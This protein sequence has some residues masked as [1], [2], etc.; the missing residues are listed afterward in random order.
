MTLCE[1]RRT[2]TATATAA[3]SGSVAVAVAAQDEYRRTGLA[4]KVTGKQLKRD[5]EVVAGR[6]DG[7]GVDA[8]GNSRP[9]GYQSAP[10]DAAI[11]V[12]T[13]PF[14]PQQVSRFLHAWYLAVERHSTG[15]ASPDITRRARDEAEDLLARLRESPALHDLTVNPLLLTLIATV[16][17]HH[18]ALPGSRAELYA[19]ICQVLLWRRQAAK[20][21]AVE[22]RG[23][24]KE[25]IMRL[26]AFEM[27]R[28]QVR[29]LATAEA[30]A[31][32]RPALRRTA[33]DQ[34]VTATEFLDEAASNG[35][36]IE[37]EN[38]VRAFA[39][40]TF[41]EYLAAAHIRE[42]NL[43][44]LLAGKV[45]DT[46]WR[47]T[48]L[49]YAAGADAGPIVQACLAADTVP[50]LA[51]AF[52]CAEEA[53]ELAEDLRDQLESIRAAGL[54]RDADPQRR[55][56]MTGITITR[57]LRRVIYGDSGVRVCAQPVPASIYQYF[58]EDM[59]ARGQH[60]PPDAPAQTRPGTGD[61][62]AAGMRGSD[63][64]EF[65]GWVNDIT[66]GQPGYRLP[67]RAE[68]QDP[69]IR[70]ALTS[71]LD[72]AAYGIWLAPGQPGQPPSSARP[73]AWPGPGPSTG[74][75]SS[76]GSRP[77]SATHRSP[78]PSCRS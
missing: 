16:H 25:R 15:A 70:E 2:S 20:K 61:H 77:T 7:N 52:D 60:C 78:A 62:P 9:L 31:I 74:F 32:V 46:W 37:R 73:A 53:G 17:R 28:R 29:D 33:K 34:P 40:L 68:I 67:A 71:Q 5:G 10:V 56:L 8:D 6:G 13:Q 76:S 59:A 18:G 48:T 30:A 49:L 19:Q 23:Q 55:R 14:T 41:Q 54:S 75:R 64:T 45:G 35:L 50:A 4:P 1:F 22:P 11:T 3:P 21:L 24:Q 58:L 12:Q 26:L 38:G 65:A 43:Q 44:D 66:G 36:F 63:A 27:M 39:H 47:E 69:A 57:Q 72:P 51:L 42:K